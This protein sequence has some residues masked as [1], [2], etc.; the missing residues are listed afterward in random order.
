M[1]FGS[2]VTYN[3]LGNSQF[4]NWRSGVSAVNAGTAGT[5]CKLVCMGDSTTQGIGA[6]ANG[7]RNNISYPTIMEQALATWGLSIQMDNFDCGG[8][9]GS[10]QADSRVALGG[11]GP[12]FYNSGA[13]GAGGFYITT[14]NSG[15]TA[16][17]TLGSAATYDRI[18]YTYADIGGSETMG[19]ALDGGGAISGSPFTLTG[20]NSFNTLGATV[21]IP[22]ASH[23]SVVLSQAASGQC[24][25]QGFAFWSHASPKVELYNT[26]VPGAVSGMVG[27]GATTGVG[28]WQG[29]YQLAP[30]LALINFGI[31]DIANGVSASTT[32]SNLSLMITGLQGINCDVVLILPTPGTYANYGTGMPA[33]RSAL[34]SVCTTY[35]VPMIDLSG[36]YNDSASDFN[37]AGFQYSDGVHLT[38]AGYADVAD[39]IAVL[40]EG[41]TPTSGAFTGSVTDS[42]TSSDAATF[43]SV[44]LSMGDSAAATDTLGTRAIPA[45]NFLDSL[46]VNIHA[47]QGYSTDYASLINIIRVANVRDYL[48]SG[49]SSYWT[50][51]HGATTPAVKLDALMPISNSS[52]LT[53]SIAQ[54]GALGSMLLSVEGPNEPNNFLISYNSVTGG[55]TG[56]WTSVAQFQTDLMTGVA[57][58]FPV[59]NVSE[60]GAEH[61]N[62]GLQFITIPPSGGA[63]FP[64]GTPFADY[65]NVHNYVIGNGVVYGDNQ[66]WSAA[67][68]TLNARW[69]GLYGNCGVTF[70]QGFTGYSNGQLLTLPRVT[71]ETGW[72]SSISGNTEYIQGIL[73]VNVY[74]AQF[75]RGWAY[76]FIYELVDGEGGGGSFGLFHGSPGLAPKPAATYLTNLTTILWD[77]AVTTS[78]GMLNMTIVGEVDT[79]HSLLLQKSDGTYELCIWGENA[80]QTPNTVTVNFGQTFPSV[81]VYDVTIGTTPTNTYSNTNS[82]SVV[83]TD[84]A[85]IIEMSSQAT[86]G[87][88]VPG[89]RAKSQLQQVA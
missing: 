57:G 74:L 41:V 73:T 63:T 64:D 29:A 65:A 85:L 32:A 13:I 30:T 84:H 22:S 60:T 72:D 15:D 19:I 53:A 49:G 5:R 59:F 43:R 88:F 31:N 62:V 4:P 66:A 1:P 45:K 80:A 39:R 3:W 38:A 50:T 34:Q 87:S 20:T 14:Q 48:L 33:L 42:A 25:I 44:S 8:T 89:G 7:W 23:S 9:S 21:T 67:D 77:T 70:G 27:S 81:N 17:F 79:N 12:A 47:S 36:T 75:T 11:S 35:G 83:L 78:P 18:D 58:A 86:S 40:L 10:N 2:T 46:G 71:T 76:T 68:P 6:N 56:S 54:A 37:A 61:D 52:D 51:L 82:V 16:T 28:Q 55:G 24:Y 26:G 69:D